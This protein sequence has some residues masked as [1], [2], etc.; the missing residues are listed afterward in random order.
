MNEA[1]GLVG[2]QIIPFFAKNGTQF[3]V[4]FGQRAFTHTPPSGYSTICASNLTAPTIKD[5]T[6]YHETILYTGND[7]AA[8]DITDLEFQPDFVWIKIEMQQIHTI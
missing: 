1:S 8:R 7:G 3:Q 5:P 6:K 2:S 4:N